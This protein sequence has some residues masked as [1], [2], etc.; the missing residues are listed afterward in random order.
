M[1]CARLS[2][3]HLHTLLRAAFN[4]KHSAHTHIMTIKTHEDWA[5]KEAQRNALKSN[6]KRTASISEKNV[7]V[8]KNPN[9][10]NIAAMITHN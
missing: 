1:C 9:E 6:A 2:T 10:K 5:L 3:L 8:K 7:N 4:S